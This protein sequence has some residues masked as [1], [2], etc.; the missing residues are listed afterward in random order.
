L[1]RRSLD[2]F[3]ELRTASSTR[4]DSKHAGKHAVEHP[5][6]GRHRDEARTAAELISAKRPSG[7]ARAG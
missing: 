1:P 6:L 5:A 2:D 4:Q 7:R 3:Y